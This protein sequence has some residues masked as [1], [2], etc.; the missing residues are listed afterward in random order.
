METWGFQPKALLI[1]STSKPALFLAIGWYTHQDS[2]PCGPWNFITSADLFFILSL[3][4][5]LLQEHGKF[6]FRLKGLIFLSTC[7]SKQQARGFG[8]SSPPQLVNFVNKR[9]IK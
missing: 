1:L 5:F 9:K 8:V 7:F 4:H 2:L 6:V 3:P